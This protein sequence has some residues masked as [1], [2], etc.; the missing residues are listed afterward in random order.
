MSVYRAGVVA[1]ML[2]TIAS[3]VEAGVV[4]G[5][6]RTRT[7]PDAAAATA[8]VYAERL[9]GPAPRTTAAFT[10]MQKNKSFQPQVL[11][12]P[13]GS[14]VT[15]PNQDPI[16]HNVFSLSGPQPFDL[17]LYRGGQARTRTFVQPGT[18]RVFCNIHPEM[19]ALVLVVPTP[20]ATLTDAA[21]RFSVDLPPG[22]YRVTAVSAR[23]EPVSIEIVSTAGAS[24][25]P[26]LALDES[27]W[28]AASHKNKYGQDYPAASYRR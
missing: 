19:T 3:A 23:A 10:L 5:V 28:A 9:D 24:Q 16:F 22:R 15:F 14:T 25:T 26:E 13:V 18:Y 8:I 27:T 12:A 7:R 11:A 21:G 6:V 4:S 17:G 1:A 20:Y 2:L